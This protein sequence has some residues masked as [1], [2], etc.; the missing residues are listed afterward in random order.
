MKVLTG[1]VSEWFKP[2]QLD[3]GDEA[4]FELTPITQQK[5]AEVQNHYD[6]SARE[7]RPTGYYLA[8]E[9]GVTNWRGVFDDED[10][11][12]KFS[13]RN[14]VMV[15]AKIAFELGA[16]VINVSTLSEDD[17]KNL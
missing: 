4:E 1:L 3:E 2:E 7:M 15:P 9:L 13:I 8:F 10:K 14:M 6:M 12:L 17:R 16:Q 11:E 5:I